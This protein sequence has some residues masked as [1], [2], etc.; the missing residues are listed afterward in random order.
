MI[1][2]N[3]TIE[4]KDT[5]ASEMARFRQIMLSIW[6]Q[7]IE[8]DKNSREINRYI[9]LNEVNQRPTEPR[10]PDK[11]HAGNWPRETSLK[12]DFDLNDQNNHKFNILKP[13]TSN[14]GNPVEDM[15]ADD[16]VYV[17][18][19]FYNEDG[20]FEGKVNE[21]ENEGSLSDVYTCTGKSKV[22]N[23]KEEE[24]ITY[25][26]IQILKENE[27][28]ISHSDFCYVAYVVKMEAGN[29]DIR[30]LECIA[31]TSFNRS[32]NINS[33]WKKLLSTSYSRVEHK[34]EMVSSLKD[35]KSK[36][37]RQALFYVLKGE[38]DLTNGAEFWDGTDFLAWGN[39]ETN[40]YNKLGQNKFDEYK[41][42]EIPKDV[43]DSYLA[44]NGT[45]IRYPIEKKFAHDKENDKGSHEDLTKKVKKQ[46]KGKDKKPILDKDGKPTFEMV[47][48]LVGA[49]YKLPAA[50]FENKDYWVSGSFYYDTGVKVSIGISGT[51]SAGKSIFWKKT[52]NRLT[53]ETPVKKEKK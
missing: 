45:S 9:K 28:N 29:E 30:E 39:S 49:R 26:N 32:K 23:T 52:K 33:T 2:K 6:R 47:D 38:N 41:F 19:H 51:I 5:S 10:T 7:Q 14:F 16:I 44:A 13:L 4:L 3:H 35:K 53:S 50:D 21:P 37:T 27:K 8:D 22:K 20:T 24:I 12:S 1:I 42:I 36:L 40:P 48:E 43:Y 17:N 31:Y 11:K 25:N 46:L 34:K 18:G 15:F